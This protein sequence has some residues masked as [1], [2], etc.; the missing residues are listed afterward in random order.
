MAD[1]QSKY[2]SHKELRVSEAAGQE[3]VGLRA[4]V[5]PH[6]SIGLYYSI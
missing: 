2:T 3:W 4:G 1:L 5:S 6:F